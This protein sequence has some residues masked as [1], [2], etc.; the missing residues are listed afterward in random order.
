[1]YAKISY[2]YAHTNTKKKERKEENEKKEKKKGRPLHYDCY[3]VRKKK[4]VS[5]KELKMS[6]T[7][8]K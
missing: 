2:S 3:E 1:M 4:Q 7:L 5:L 6:A 8:N